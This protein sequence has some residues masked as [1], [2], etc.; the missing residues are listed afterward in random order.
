VRLQ[1]Q[2]NATFA[3]ATGIGQG[4]FNATQTEV[5]NWFTEMVK[6]PAGA[7]VE[8]YLVPFDVYA[9]RQ[10]LAQQVSATKDTKIQALLD[11]IDGII[12]AYPELAEALKAEKGQSAEQQEIKVLENTSQEVIIAPTPA[13][14]KV[15]EPTFD[16]EVLT[17]LGLSANAKAHEILGVAADASQAEIE[18]AFRK[19]SLEWHP[20]K[21][22]LQTR[23]T[24]EQFDQVF[25]VLG[26]ARDVMIKRLEE[27]AA[28][29]S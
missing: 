24:K 1:A 10:S 4:N 6:S 13:T 22:I 19:R 26:Q 5:F 16:T 27:Q 8:S 28:R 3:Q 12:Q 18:K 14:P 29:T 7:S 15:P 20:D 2:S 25:K 11:S 9:V 23:Y 17:L 21:A